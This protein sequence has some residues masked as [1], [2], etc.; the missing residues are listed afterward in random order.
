[1]ASIVFN[2][3]HTHNNSY[4][5]LTHFS[6]SSEKILLNC[7]A[8]SHTKHPLWE[9]Q[10]I[11]WLSIC[12]RTVSDIFCGKVFVGDIFCGKSICGSRFSIVGGLVQ[13]LFKCDQPTALTCR[14]LLQNQKNFTK[15]ET[16]PRFS[17]WRTCCSEDH[18]W[19][20]TWHSPGTLRAFFPRHRLCGGGRREPQKHTGADISTQGPS[21]WIRNMTCVWRATILP[22]D[23]SAIEGV[24]GAVTN[25]AGQT[26]LCHSTQ[27][28]DFICTNTRTVKTEGNIT[29][30]K[31]NL[32]AT[33]HHR[34]GHPDR[35]E[36]Q[37]CHYPFPSTCRS[38]SRRGII[39][40]SR[41]R[42]RV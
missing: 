28:L 16:T 25:L 9:I 8:L 17:S 33:T 6:S 36:D 42:Q 27:E 1:M 7:C 10:N 5:P 18:T 32:I 22:Q 29:R 19:L 35:G 13:Q 4:F 2:A 20:C 26:E 24:G 31:E 12:G 37:H 41:A 11:V 39:R 30:N 15:A 14:M 40:T 38:Q 3:P 34:G 23:A 21:G